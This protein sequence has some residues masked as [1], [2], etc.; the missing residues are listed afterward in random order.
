MSNGLNTQEGQ[1][2]EKERIGAPIPR[3]PY[4]YAGWRR[5]SAPLPRVETPIGSQTP[6]DFGESRFDS[7]ITLPQQLDNLNEFRAEEQTGL[8]KIANGIAKMGIFA[9]TTFLD[10]TIGMLYGAGK[11]IS[12]GD[13]SG[14]WDNEISNAMSDV[15]R[16]S[17]KALPNYYTESELDGNIHFTA[18][19]LGDKFLKNLGFTFGAIGSA[20]LFNKGV[21]LLKLP[22]IA[23]YLTKSK[24][25]SAA[26][27]FILGNAVQSLNEA[28]VE[29]NN[30]S[31]EWYEMQKQQL[32]EYHEKRKEELLNT[33]VDE[34]DYARLS[35]LEDDAYQRA[36]QRLGEDTARM[37][38][39]DMAG[40]FGLLMLTNSMG[41]GRM[42]ARG[43]NTQRRILNAS[44][45]LNKLQAGKGLSGGTM[46]G[47]A[48]GLKDTFVEGAEE[49]SQSMIAK[50]T[51]N[52]YGNDVMSFYD[53]SIDFETTKNSV[54]MLNA[55]GKGI[56]EQ[57]NDPL[58]WEEFLIGSLTGATGVIRVGKNNV[59][60]PLIGPVG[61]QGGI[62]G[63]TM[64]SRRNAAREN[65]II[66]RVNESMANP[67][68]TAMLR[69]INRHVT[70]Q[71]KMDLAAKEGDSK[72]FKDA[73]Y[74]QLISD[75]ITFDACGM[76]TD[77]K[78]LINT[79]LGN[80]H[81]TDEQLQSIRES[82]KNIV[83]GK[84]VGPYAEFTE[85]ADGNNKM[86]E[87]L[88]QT[89]KALLDAV[90]QYQDAYKEIDMQTDGIFS[91][92]QLAELV[93]M[94]TRLGDWANRS[95]ELTSSIVDRL[96]NLK[97]HV[98]TNRDGKLNEFITVNAVE[99]EELNLQKLSAY[100]KSSGK[101]HIDIDKSV[102]ALVDIIEKN[103]RML[104]PML[105]SKADPRSNS[106]LYMGIEAWLQ[107]L[108]NKAGELVTDGTDIHIDELLQE[109][110]D[111]QQ[112][113]LDAQEFNSKLTEFMADPK[114]FEAAH[115]KSDRKAKKAET[116]HKAEK[117]VE[118]AKT[119]SNA[120]NDSGAKA[121]LNNAEPEV[122][123]A[124][125]NDPWVKYFNNKIGYLEQLS[126]NID[127]LEDVP[128]P[129][130]TAAREALEEVFRSI[131]TPKAF[132]D[133][134]NNP[135][136]II[137]DLGLDSDPY[138][139]FVINAAFQKQTANEEF[140]KLFS[141]YTQP[142]GAIVFSDPK[143]SNDG[144]DSTN[145]SVSEEPPTKEDQFAP[146][147]NAELSIPNSADFSQDATDSS[148][149]IN[150][151]SYL[152]T[153][154][155]LIALESRPRIN[156]YT[157]TW[158]NIPEAYNTPSYVVIDA[159]L[160]VN[161]QAAW[162]YIY[163]TDDGRPI[164]Y[165]SLLMSP[166][167]TKGSEIYF[168]IKKDIT[169]K[170]DND[171]IEHYVVFMYWKNPDTNTYIPVGTVIT[172]PQYKDAVA[173]IE[174]VSERDIALLEEQQDMLDNTIYIHPSL[175]TNVH[176]IKPG[177]IP[178]IDHENNLKDIIKPEYI[179]GDNPKVRF[180]IVK[181][182]SSKEPG[183]FTIAGV[184]DIF[185]K[186]R[187]YN[188][189]NL[190]TWSGRIVMMIPRAD[191]L[192]TAVPVRTKP[193]SA[194]DIIAN[195]NT[196][197]YHE[198]YEA[199][200]TLINTTDTYNAGEA[201]KTLRQLL[202][203]GNI[204][205]GYYNMN[206][207][208][209][210]DTGEVINNFTKVKDED[211]KSTETNA[212]Y[213]VLGFVNRTDYDTWQAERESDPNKILPTRHLIKTGDTDSD[214]RA[215]LDLVKDSREENAG[216]I[217]YYNI[218]VTK[219]NNS[220]Y[221]SN[222]IQGGILT[223]NIE[224]PE[225]YGDFF[226]IPT[227]DTS[228]GKMYANI[229]ESPATSSTPTKVLSPTSQSGITIELPEYI[230]FNN[231]GN[232]YKVIKYPNGIIRAH[233]GDNSIVSTLETVNLGNGVTAHLSQVLEQLS[234]LH[235]KSNQNLYKRFQGFLYKNQSTDV[236]IF[237]GI[238]N[239]LFVKNGDRY[240]IITDP[241][242]IQSI[243]TVVNSNNIINNIA[244]ASNNITPTKN[245]SLA[246]SYTGS[247][248]DSA[249]NIVK[250][251]TW[252]CTYKDASED[253]VKTIYY[254]TDNGQVSKIAGIKVNDNIYLSGQL[255]SV[256]NAPYIN[257]FFVNANGYRSNRTFD[258][259]IPLV[260]EGE[261]VVPTA[262]TLEELISKVNQNAIADVANA[263]ASPNTSKDLRKFFKQEAP[264]IVT[265]PDTTNTESVIPDN[266]TIRI[267]LEAITE[268]FTKEDSSGN[269]V[270]N[271]DGG[272]YIDN[273]GK[274]YLRFHCLQGF[275]NSLE[276]PSF[277]VASN[278][279]SRKQQL[280]SDPIIEG[281]IYDAYL[282]SYFMHGDAAKAEA[283][284]N[285]AYSDFF[286]N[287]DPSIR[288]K[289]LADK[290]KYL[291]NLNDKFKD[292]Q[293][294][295][296][297]LKNAGYKFLTNNLIVSAHV[298]YSKDN[299]NVNP[300]TSYLR[301]AGE[302]DML[303][304][305]DGEYY[306]IDFKNSKSDPSL[307]EFYRM[308]LAFYKYALENS[309]SNLS[310]K[311]HTY[312]WIWHDKNSNHDSLVKPNDDIN[313]ANCSIPIT[314]EE[315]LALL[316][317]SKAPNTLFFSRVAE[318]AAMEI[319]ANA[320]TVVQ[321]SIEPQQNN[322]QR[323]LEE[324]IN[325][326]RESGFTVKGKADM[327]KFLQE[328]GLN[329]VQES[330]VTPEVEQEMK[331]IKDKA[332]A[333]GTFMKAP[334]GN[335]TNLN[336][337]QWLQ[338]RTKAFKDWFGDWTKITFNKDGKVL[339]IPDDASKVVDENG[340]PLVVYHHTDNPNLTEFSTD[341]DNYF[342]KDGG[343]KE[344]IFFDENETGTLNRKYDISVFLNIRDLH[345]YNET[346]EQL[347]QRGTTYRQV[348]NESVAVNNVDGGVHM[349]DFDDN[350]MEHQSIWIVHNPNQIKS[351]TDNNG[352][353]SP[354]SNNIQ[355]LRTPDG[356]L[357]GFVDKNNNIYIDET[358][359]T[360]DT[361]I[362]E[363]THLW[364]RVVAKD[365]SELWQRG[366]EL[367]KQLPLWSEIEKD[368]NYG[369]KWDNRDDKEFLIASEVHARLVGKEGN[370]EINKSS[371]KSAIAAL[372]QWLKDFWDAI[373]ST[374]SKWTKKDLD[375]LTIEDFVKM[376]IK[377]FL[378]RENLVA[379]LNDTEPT[380]QESNDEI[381]NAIDEELGDLLLREASDTDTFDKADIDKEVKWLQ[382]KLGISEND[383]LE[384]VDTLIELNNEHGTKAYGQFKDATITLSRMMAKGTAYHEAFHTVFHLMLKPSEICDIIDEAIKRYNTSDS[385]KLE[386][387]LANDFMD[388][389][390]DEE[391][392]EP[393]LSSKIKAFFTKLKRF[394]NHILG[395][396]DYIDGLFYRIKNGSFADSYNEDIAKS[397]N[398]ATLVSKAIL[399]NNRQ[400]LDTASNGQKSE[401]YEALKRELGGNDEA[402]VAKA[403]AMSPDFIGWLSIKQS[404]EGLSNESL[405]DKNGEVKAPFVLERLQQLGMTDLHSYIPYNSNAS[406]D[407]N[408][409]IER[410][411]K[412]VKSSLQNI[413]V[414]K[415]K[416]AY[417]KF[418]NDYLNKYG[419]QIIGTVKNK[420]IT[421]K[422]VLDR[423]KIT[424]VFNDNGEVKSINQIISED[425]SVTQ[426]A[427]ETLTPRQRQLLSNDNLDSD[428]WNSLSYEEQQSI[429]ECL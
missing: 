236:C 209:N 6:Q 317:G 58:A 24:Q 219:L 380:V 325:Y 306:I 396:E 130:R 323:A 109:L 235:D 292:V 370:K 160:P 267:F 367:M 277:N 83:D 85:D 305:K 216:N 47:I 311:V 126:A 78:N 96:R 175:K 147:G 149:P 252:K 316:G 210:Q 173:L 19:F 224:K 65:A 74:S 397:A 80:G 99:G 113:T 159:Q 134:V 81:L 116:K 403:M 327:E 46:R 30:N 372:K 307:N 254:L 124:A 331:Q 115:K 167:F 10:G 60:V 318:K 168:G 211:D 348:V 394:L 387:N 169:Y 135:W 260:L 391:Y 100:L 282:R 293:N 411:T 374:F 194:D 419:I 136:A 263:M 310:G 379:R 249:Y 92:D 275:F 25:A 345:E 66:K 427:W 148:Q 250:E 31:R 138:R 393:T 162:E 336:E 301:I 12:E 225:T 125:E 104:G 150:S 299:S 106:T 369:A 28:R 117:V 303:M 3:V 337:R 35:A 55:M 281:N 231:S 265:T 133:F 16:W 187:G 226:T 358:S 86:R 371:D 404:S 274:N 77:Y 75:I 241:A 268:S 271:R 123:V 353:F 87:K 155:P 158:S 15:Q 289:Y 82:T 409:S 424:K 208:V 304:E 121:T 418:V 157:N 49:M 206:P 179:S 84:D 417:N 132:S 300:V 131:Q 196:P 5:Q 61:L 38:N 43:F 347:H 314:A 406:Q 144:V 186:I 343:T 166:E 163:N 382:D 44:R 203:M 279:T 230:N 21:G 214:I 204:R 332:I 108:K 153:G 190:N 338:V 41:L 23:E 423:R 156:K 284:A 401:L 321:T 172:R 246:L 9:G 400:T 93:W 378:N 334:N 349:K 365:N 312:G 107:N 164:T 309:S 243:K 103:K 405:Y 366:V 20:L 342:S 361:P 386:E 392:V 357:Y 217:V 238:D 184:S 177:F 415:L 329:D 425:N 33:A 402:I 37:G 161:R 297:R 11:A 185:N 339:N 248:T 228:T 420:A 295:Y 222:I 220:E 354:E 205:I 251:S 201:L 290:D 39:A 302:M 278:D 29:A 239:Y 4:D 389:M 2:R 120:G 344:A 262:K 7:R 145:P 233:K 273:F 264:V 182:K 283:D 385:I 218:D 285:K 89:R 170:F 356:N 212:D 183:I 207:Q 143:V 193:V 151:I 376:P 355:E 72:A 69:G 286:A 407:D 197:F 140:A 308:Q 62:L 54:D 26:F 240:D 146:A 363:Y 17:E 395:L 227:Y 398:T 242:N 272:V 384:I 375:D 8:G 412:I 198:I 200:N 326:L 199:I 122:K 335:P 350:Q 56:H 114:K 165:K 408:L 221:I 270:I 232:N 259:D 18:N 296:N 324:L 57:L 79:T 351:A 174:R 50:G 129:Y 119:Q 70:E 381:A 1:L 53:A 298:P 359:A 13:W 189:M 280:I 95:K 88:E 276:T 139:N 319:Q 330:L 383:G 346:K 192:Y 426:N 258:T 14:L 428:T 377:D 118:E 341:F 261:N 237:D 105:I 76:L 255:H 68:I 98:Y 294:I 256:N 244:T 152:Q 247:F 410:Y 287:T 180:G 101:R 340:E 322:K 223:C 94:K 257:I 191:D 178:Y 59:D 52:Y 315:S 141:Q 42:Y 266:N 34:A 213:D 416:D 202:Y 110:R 45:K 142:T 127:S 368:S 429:I 27:S 388:Y 390:I 91:E 36:L 333:D 413:P 421:I 328:N 97:E 154:L 245:E 362:H 171:P 253:D 63:A 313:L 422:D 288:T 352:N 399:A 215:F 195:K 176:T 181:N 364:D 229:E 137:S 111:L 71:G 128:Q 360:L 90:D 40:N 373:K 67:R 414:S 320:G 269:K 64:E 102:D 291:S 234:Y 48:T 112:M 22:K 32:D 188:P 73:E 51:G